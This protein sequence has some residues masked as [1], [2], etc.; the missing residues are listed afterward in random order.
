MMTLVATQYI[1]HRCRNSVVYRFPVSY[2]PFRSWCARCPHCR[3]RTQQSMTER[4]GL[5]RT[6]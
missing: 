3:K 1:C 6:R 4:R 5:R 2:V